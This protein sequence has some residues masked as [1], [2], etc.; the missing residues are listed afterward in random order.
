MEKVDI[1]IIGAGVIGLAVA[2]ALAEDYE[3]V[4]LVDAE[5]TFGQHTSSR[6]SEVIHSGIYYPQKTKKARYCVEGAEMLYAFAERFN[7]PFK[8]SG[9]LVVATSAE[10]IPALEILKQ[11]GE[12]NQVKG[13]E[14]IDQASCQKLEPQ[15]KAVAALH[16]PGTGIID[17]HNLMQRLESEAEKKGACVVY[18]M[19]VISI[20]TLDEGYLINFSN[21]EAFE[22]NTVINCAGLHSDEIANMVGINVRREKLV[23]H[24][25]KGE[26]F[27]SSKVKNINHLIYP[28]PDPKG[29]FLGIHLC[30]NLMGDVRFGPNAYFVDE[31]DYMMDETHKDE[32]LKA[33]TRYIDIDPEYLHPDDTGIRP[34]LQKEGEAFRDFYIE[35]ESM[36]G[37][38]NFINCIGI[39]SP[40]LT[41]CL[42]IAREVKEL[43]D[44]R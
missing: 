9:K 24:W 5:E 28:I 11:N 41:A 6:N 2:N 10:E 43:V 31:L 42:A 13:L 21:G 25:C 22:A 36:K 29:I 7:I 1:L 20:D 38:P 8:K 33:I 44:N 18:D 32:F 26:Y 16:V 15:I 35:E 34:K 27:K 40:G 19:E 23:L 3:D 14:I 17:S 4:V 39:E 37:F 12:K 30:F